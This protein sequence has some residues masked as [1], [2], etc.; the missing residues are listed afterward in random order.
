MARYFTL[1]LQ[2]RSCQQWINYIIKAKPAFPKWKEPKNPC[3][4]HKKFRGPTKCFRGVG[5]YFRAVNNFP[6][7]HQ[8]I[9]GDT[10]MF[11]G[12][13]YISNI[14]N[15]FPEVEQPRKLAKTN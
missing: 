6:G 11:A 9:S 15:E 8:K 3:L 4:K 5:K 1:R 2:C 12:T 10:K 13:T 14:A 7:E